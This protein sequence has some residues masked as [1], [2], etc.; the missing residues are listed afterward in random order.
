ML[1]PVILV[2]HMD[3]LCISLSRSGFL[4]VT[5]STPERTVSRL[6]TAPFTAI[7]KKGL[8]FS[9]FYLRSCFRLL[10]HQNPPSQPLPRRPPIPRKMKFFAVLTVLATA[11]VVQAMPV[12]SDVD[13][14]FPLYADFTLQLPT[15]SGL[16]LNLD[17]VPSS[18]IGLQ[19]DRIN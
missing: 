9:F 16:P 6:S 12:P 5:L 15:G 1:T 19:A 13:L 7:F 2:L 11:V 4:Q 10:L 3:S 8:T 18:V 17:V 14:T